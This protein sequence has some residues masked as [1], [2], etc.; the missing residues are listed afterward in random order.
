MFQSGLPR[1]ASRPAGRAFAPAWSDRG[2]VPGVPPDS[3]DPAPGAAPGSGPPVP[4][5]CP[6]RVMACV[7]S[8]GCA[9]LGRG[10]IWG[11]GDAFWGE[12]EAFWGEAEAFRGEGEALRQGCHGLM[13]SR[14]YTLAPPEP[15]GFF[16]DPICCALGVSP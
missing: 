2:G 4:S 5:L 8:P 3:P 11:E 1:R 13:G 10:A 6:A 12:A 14:G 9:T 7:L 15:G 16:M